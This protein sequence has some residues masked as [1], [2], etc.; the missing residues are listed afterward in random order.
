M[1]GRAA[2]QHAWWPAAHALLCRH[3][4]P[5]ADAEPFNPHAGVCITW[6]HQNLLSY[7]LIDV[8]HSDARGPGLLSLNKEGLLSLP[9]R[10][11]W[12]WKHCGPTVPSCSSGCSSYQALPQLL[13]ALLLRRGT[14]RC[15]C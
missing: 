10:L 15:T 3:D 9:V 12:D 14:G 5:G 2:A 7:G 6:I 11:W 8:V 4:D 1:L 13:H